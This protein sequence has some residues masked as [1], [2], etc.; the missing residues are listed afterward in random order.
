MVKESQQALLVRVSAPFTVFEIEQPN[1]VTLCQEHLLRLADKIGYRGLYRS[2]TIAQ[3]K[4]L[5]AELQS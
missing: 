4:N 1:I 2:K 3:L 5:I